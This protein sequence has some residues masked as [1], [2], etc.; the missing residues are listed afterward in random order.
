[1]VFCY[2]GEIV[3]GQCH[4]TLTPQCHQV[5]PQKFGRGFGAFDAFCSYLSLSH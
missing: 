3:I 1:M 4:M 2:F 5:P